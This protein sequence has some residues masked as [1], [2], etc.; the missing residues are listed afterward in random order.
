M[1]GNIIKADGAVGRYVGDYTLIDQDGR[2]FKIKEFLDRPVVLSFI[3]TR[4]AH[5]CSTITAHLGSIFKEAEGFLGKGFYA[6]TIGFDVEND[7]LEAMKA[8]GKRFGV[9]AYL[10]WGGRV[11][12]RSLN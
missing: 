4:C 9:I 6:L 7:T 8:Y 11:R 12:S 2:G 3:Y 1:E 5:T 10:F